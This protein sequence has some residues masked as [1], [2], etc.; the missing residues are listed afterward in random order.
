MDERILQSKS[1]L[2]FLISDDMNNGSYNVFSKSR[3][4]NV[5]PIQDRN[6]KSMK[7]YF[8]TKLHILNV[9]SKH[10]PFA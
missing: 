6:E 4:L 7:R 1:S 8:M 2:H 10:S 9:R 3:Y 5:A